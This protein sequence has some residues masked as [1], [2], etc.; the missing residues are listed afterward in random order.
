MNTKFS[1]ASRRVL[2]LASKEWREVLRDRIFFALAF[3]LPV[4]LMF[5]FTFGASQEVEH[6]PFMV[7]DED[8][9]VLSREYAQ[10]FIASRYFE[11]RGSLKSRGA[12]EYDHVL[13][14][15]KIRFI[16]VIPAHFEE[17]LLTGRPTQVQTLF[18]ATFIRSTRTAESYAEAINAAYSGQLARAILARRSR[19]TA[20]RAAAALQPLRVETR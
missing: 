13:V 1:D 7:A 2:A 12:S 9:T 14:A 19:L 11:Y 8:H 4:M 5:V 16:L 6:V 10:Q 3:F 15:G 18:D 20:A 17:R